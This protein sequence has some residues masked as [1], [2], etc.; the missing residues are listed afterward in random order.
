MSWLSPCHYICFTQTC[1]RVGWTTR[2]KLINRISW[3]VLLCHRTWLPLQILC[4]QGKD[5]WLPCAPWHLTQLTTR[6]HHL[7]RMKTH[8]YNTRLSHTVPNWCC[9]VWGFTNIF[10]KLAP[11]NGQ[12]AKHRHFRYLALNTDVR[13]Q[14]ASTFISTCTVSQGAARNG[15]SWRRTIL[16]T[17]AALRY[18]F[19]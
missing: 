15:R 5:I 1:S 11:L 14:V 17:S 10:S 19:A 8:T 4:C 7:H 16:Q 13:R 18:H 3:H 6:N 12:F 9:W 2:H